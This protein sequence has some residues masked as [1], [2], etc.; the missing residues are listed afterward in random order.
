MADITYTLVLRVTS[1]PA[2]QN[3]LAES[4]LKALAEKQINEINIQQGG[5]TIK[6]SSLV[7]Q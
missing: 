1:D 6:T 4:E 5:T 7:E 3:T 2:G